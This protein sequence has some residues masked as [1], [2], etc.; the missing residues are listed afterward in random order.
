MRNRSKMHAHKNTLIDIKSEEFKATL[1]ELKKVLE[2]TLLTIDEKYHLTVYHM[3][4]YFAARD[5]RIK[6]ERIKKEREK[7]ERHKNE[8]IKNEREKK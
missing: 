3:N 5:E 2:C 7:N 1:E 8:I 4:K 6:N